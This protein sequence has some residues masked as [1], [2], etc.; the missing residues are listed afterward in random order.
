MNQEK[1]GKFISECRKDKNM[2]QSELADKLNIST[3]AVSKWE[4]GIC[5]MDMS[6]L[7]PLSELLDVSINEILNGEKIKKSALKEKT[8]EILNKTIEYSNNRL[9]KFKKKT[10][11]IVLF[12]FFLTSIVTFVIDY[13]RVRKNLNPLFMIPVSENGNNYTYLGFGYKMEKEVSISPNEPLSQNQKIKFGLW[14]FSWDV[15]VFNPKP[16]NLWVINNENKNLTHIGSYCITDSKGKN[17]RSE[18]SLSVPLEDIIYKQYLDSKKD[19]IIL[20]DSSNDI[21]ITRITFYD[22]NS[23]KID[24][25]IVYD[26]NSFMVPNLHG[27]YIVVIDTIC[28]RGTAWYSFKIKIN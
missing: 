7:K 27:E 24:I 19:D 5:L 13:N 3:N 28:D 16:R 17:K 6:L 20:L 21:N 2:T 15:Q 12:I 22:L 23:E 18:C 4:R 25:P 8:D 26:N 9:K 10:L 1:I 11:I 14:I